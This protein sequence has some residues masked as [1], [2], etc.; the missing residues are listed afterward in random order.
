MTQFPSDGLHG[1]SGGETVPV[2]GLAGPWGPRALRP[3][4]T[5]HPEVIFI[6]SDADR[7]TMG[8]EGPT[9]PILTA[10]QGVVISLAKYLV[11]ILTLILIIINFCLVQDPY[12][13]PNGLWANSDSLQCRGWEDRGLHCH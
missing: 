3:I 7:P 2:H 10:H 12:V 1:P 4:P 11:M 13:E 6:E 5:V 8:P 9:H